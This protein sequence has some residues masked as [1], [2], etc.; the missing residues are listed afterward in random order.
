MHKRETVCA[1]K[2]PDI[3]MGTALLGERAVVEQTGCTSERR[4]N[5]W[6]FSVE[7]GGEPSLVTRAVHRAIEATGCFNVLDRKEAHAF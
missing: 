1:H 7:N 3:D 4:R 5:A 2:K 6:V